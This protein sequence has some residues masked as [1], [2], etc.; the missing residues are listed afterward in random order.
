MLDCSSGG[1]VRALTGKAYNLNVAGSNPAA[2][3][4]WVHSSVVEH[5]III[6]S[7]TCVDDSFQTGIIRMAYP[8]RHVPYPHN[9][10]VQTGLETP[11]LAINQFPKQKGSH[12]LRPKLVRG[13][14]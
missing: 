5:Q 8:S 1:V 4:S 9:G 13:M 7:R 14:T 10:C 12:D 6:A 11:K 3:T 2:P